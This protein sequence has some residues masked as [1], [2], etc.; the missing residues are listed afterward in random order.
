MARPRNDFPKELFYFWRH[1]PGKGA[2][3]EGRDSANRSIGWKLEFE[4]H[5]MSLSDSSNPSYSENFDM[6]RADPK[7]FYSSVNRQISLSFFL[8][9]MNKDEHTHNHEVLLARLGRMTYPIY[10]SGN[11]Y[12]SP[13]VLFQIGKLVK[14]YG[15]ITSL[16]YDWKPEYPWVEQRPLYTDVSMTIKVLANSTGERPNAKKHYFIT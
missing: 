7:V 2:L 1:D 4:A 3:S 6:G 5:I 15:V 13:H 9:G 14:G 16:T 10:Q 12:N 11:G 8:V